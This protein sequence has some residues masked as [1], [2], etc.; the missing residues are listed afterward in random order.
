MKAPIR[1]L[2]ELAF[3]EFIDS[4]ADATQRA[5]ERVLERRGFEVITT[6]EWVISAREIGEDAGRAEALASVAFPLFEAFK[7]AEGPRRQRILAEIEDCGFQVGKETRARLL[8]ADTGEEVLAE[9]ELDDLGAVA[10]GP[11]ASEI[12]LKADVFDEEHGV[13]VESNA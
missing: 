3:R 8:E 9:E 13:D 7:N 5:A 6:E 11:D 10:P 4:Q 2:E 12:V 1:F